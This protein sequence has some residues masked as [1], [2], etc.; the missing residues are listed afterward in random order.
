M[1]ESHIF[2]LPSVTATNGDKEGLPN[3]L[4]EALASGLPVIST[5]HAGIPELIQDGKSGFLVKERD[6]Y[7]LSIRLNQLI[8][9][10]SLWSTFSSKG[11]KRVEEAFNL[12]HQIQKLEQIY[13]ELLTC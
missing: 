1:Q 6:A 10:P 8:E 7:T 2:I 12:Q 4:K 13:T 9:N 5:Y 11:R 3:V